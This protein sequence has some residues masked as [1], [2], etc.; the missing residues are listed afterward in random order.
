MSHR[1]EAGLYVPL[2]ALTSLSFLEMSMYQGFTDSK[3]QIPSYTLTKKCELL[4]DEYFGSFLLWFL[5]V[6]AHLV[7]YL[8]INKKEIQN[9]F[10]QKCDG[11]QSAYTKILDQE[12]LV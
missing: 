4:L 2:N 7:I 3:P 10:R 12:D 1:E 6:I 5:F 8:I 11:T 9:K